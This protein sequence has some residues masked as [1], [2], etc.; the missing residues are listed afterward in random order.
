MGARGTLFASISCML[1]IV[2][3]AA[4][5]MAAW[6][7]EGEEGC[8]TACA[9]PYGTCEGSTCVCVEGRGGN[10][11]QSSLR[12]L[13]PG[14]IYRNQLLSPGTWDYYQLE[15]PDTGNTG[16][17]QSNGKVIQFGFR[18]TGGYP[19]GYIKYEEFPTDNQG[20]L[21]FD[22]NSVSS[23][24]GGLF[25]L[26]A[27]RVSNPGPYFLG[28]TNAANTGGSNM[29]Y[30]IE[31]ETYTDEFMRLSPIVSIVVGGIAAI[32]LCIMLFA[33]KRVA[34]S[35]IAN[36][37]P[38]RVNA[39]QQAPPTRDFGLSK[40]VIDSFETKIYEDLKEESDVACA[41]CLDNFEP[42]VRVM[43]LPRC[44]HIFHIGCVKEWLVG[45]TTC[46]I[47]RT[48]L[49]WNGSGIGES[50]MLLPS[51]PPEEGVNIQM[52]VISASSSDQAINNTQEPQENDRVRIDIRPEN[53]NTSAEQNL[54][55]QRSSYRYFRRMPT[56][57]FI[58]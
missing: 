45:H 47:C 58:A 50:D 44:A 26:D 1:F 33:C 13:G 10:D 57:H 40:D 27:R 22:F 5:G 3:A 15:L 32:T 34:S 39:I 56:Y 16:G 23:S 29:S 55:R 4:E 21:T 37:V 54:E 24:M 35:R 31:M 14:G 43:V 9:S 17:S 12:N 53:T 25:R 2:Q 52:T 28:I 6:R 38:R 20:S 42:N 19:A 41:I 48:E 11:C 18:W 49:T 8:P 51:S 36:L 30:L 7:R 46:P